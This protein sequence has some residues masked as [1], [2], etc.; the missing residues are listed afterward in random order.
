M[1]ACLLQDYSLTEEMFDLL[2]NPHT[3]ILDLLDSDLSP[4][5]SPER[6][7]RICGLASVRCSVIIN[8][9]IL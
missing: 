6:N 2:L 3:K 1:A 7:L 5:F 8:S 4:D 9:A